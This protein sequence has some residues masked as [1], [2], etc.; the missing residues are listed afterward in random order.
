MQILRVRIP[1]QRSR[2]A[3]AVRRIVTVIGFLFLGIFQPAWSQTSW[4]FD[5]VI[6]HTCYDGDTCMV[7]IPGVHPLFGDHIPV[8][9]LGIDTP[10][11]KGQCEREK[12][13][14][15]E[16]RDFARAFLAEA[17]EIRL[18]QVSRGDKYFR[19]LGRLEADGRDLSQSLLDA[20]LAVAYNGGTKTARWCE[21]S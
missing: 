16:A 7:S 12:T 14:A 4:D 19:V 1:S 17:K 20:H 11:I 21:S 13:L 5:R 9:L 18:V 6:Y 8:R 15:R 10:E 2:G 3:T